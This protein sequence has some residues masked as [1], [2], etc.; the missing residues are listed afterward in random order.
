MRCLSDCGVRTASEGWHE[1]MIPACKR[2]KHEREQ[3]SE[4]A[5]QQTSLRQCFSMRRFRDMKT[6]CSLC[7]ESRLVDG[8]ESGL[9]VSAGVQTAVV[10]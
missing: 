5:Q 10:D 9:A 7:R 6:S 2:K 4:A 3:E 1:R 8:L